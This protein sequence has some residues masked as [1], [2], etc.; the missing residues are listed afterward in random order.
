MDIKPFFTKYK[1]KESEVKII[2]CS[3][4]P[5]LMKDLTMRLVEQKRKKVLL[6]VVMSEH[7]RR[8]FDDDERDVMFCLPESIPKKSLEQG[9]YRA[10]YCRTCD[11][12]SQEKFDY[13]IHTLTNM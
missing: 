4:K 11:I 3:Q 6:V 1:S 13:L 7:N 5:H 9:E 8:V 12:T 10:C 2:D